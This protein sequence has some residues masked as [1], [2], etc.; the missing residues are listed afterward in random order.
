MEAIDIDDLTH[1]Q[2]TK[3]RTADFMRWLSCLSET[4]TPEGASARFLERWPRS[5]SAG[6]VTK[7]ATLPGTS[8]GATWASPLVPT[9]LVEPFLA[10][11][12]AASL[13]GK[14]PGLRNV[15]FHARIPVETQGA[16][17]AF[18]GQNAAKPVSAMG[19]DTG[20]TLLPTKASGIVIITAELAK[21]AIPGTE[22]ALR[23]TFVGGLTAF[24]DKAFI[25]P[26]ETSVPNEKPGSITSGVTPLTGTGSLPVDVATLLDAFYADNP[27][28]ETAVLVTSPGIKAQL[29]G[30]EGRAPFDLTI[31]TSPAA[32]GIVVALDPKRVFV[33]DAGASFATSQDVS[34]Q[35][36]S[37]PTNP[38]T[39]ATVTR[40]LWTHN[41]V[42]YRIERFVNWEAVA[43]SVQYPDGGVMSD[44]NKPY[45]DGLADKVERGERL[46]EAEVAYAREFNQV[47]VTRDAE[48]WKP[49][50]AP[51]APVP[52]LPASKPAR[53][54]M[55]KVSVEV[56]TR[57]LAVSIHRE[58]APVVARLA[59][60][61][62]DNAALK[63]ESAALRDRLLL[64]EAHS[65][66]HESQEHGAG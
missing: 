36:D 48:L 54:T 11:A 62:A 42:G 35:M 46:S 10:L 16:N 61:E 47:L 38:P 44:N 31:V 28:A 63:A 49:V 53:Q 41:E 52:P 5:L 4:S 58:V 7:A 1:A 40:D 45:C 43:G 27:S 8:T 34:V 33:A 23:E 17:F 15:P 64:L 65:V 29:V 13:L 3:I 55:A 56:F 60:I 51:L 19:F 2:L 12:R 26:S 6:I 66:I 14:I 24:V 21:L 20:V 9:P 25:D 50:A 59:V 22:D 32:A 18:V 30:V 57:V 37:A 39:A